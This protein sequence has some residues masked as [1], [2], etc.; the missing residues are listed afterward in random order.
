MLAG[1]TGGYLV[2][3]FAAAALIPLILGRGAASPARIVAALLAGNVAI[4]LFGVPWLDRFVDGQ[5]VTAIELGL[6]PFLIGDAIKLLAASALA[7]AAGSTQRL[8]SADPPTASRQCR[9]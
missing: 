1:P 5:L 4:Y 8:P 3:F 7:V 2:G 9:P 6:T